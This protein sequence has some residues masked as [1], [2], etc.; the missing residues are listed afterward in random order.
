M[1]ASHY[2]GYCEEDIELLA[3]KTSL[4]PLTL[5][6]DKGPA[7]QAV[8]SFLTSAKLELTGLWGFQ[9]LQSH[10][11]SSRLFLMIALIVWL[12]CPCIAAI[13][14]LIVVDDAII[15][16]RYWMSILAFCVTQPC[17]PDRTRRLRFR[18][19]LASIFN[20]SE[21]NFQLM[22]CKWDAVISRKHS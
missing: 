12:F 6:R 2:V 11:Q 9:L 13:L 20:Q 8:A 14:L 10:W 5:A 21:L 18:L 4:V 7:W 16:E 1:L 22:H 19:S 3:H 15:Q 17:I